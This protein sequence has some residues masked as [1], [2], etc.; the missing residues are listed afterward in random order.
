MSILKL[1]LE[2]RHKPHWG[3]GHYHWDAILKCGAMATM[4]KLE[5]PEEE[6]K[7]L[8][9]G[10]LF[11][12]FMELYFTHKQGFE[13]ADV[14]VSG[15]SNEAWR[16][17][18][19]SYARFFMEDFEP[20]CFGRVMGVERWLPHTEPGE[21]L[22]KQASKITEFFGVDYCAVLDLVVKLTA[23]DVKRLEV[24]HARSGLRLPGPGYYAV[25]HKTEGRDGFLDRLL[26]ERQFV[27]QHALWNICNPKTPLQ[28]V[29]VNVIVKVTKP[30]QRTLFVPPP[31]D[32][33]IEGLLGSLARAARLGRDEPTWINDRNCFTYNRPCVHFAEGRC[34]RSP[35][36]AM[37]LEQK[38]I[39]LKGI[40]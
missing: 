37:R 10:S 28:G 4:N 16:L 20:N 29:L 18:A 6:Q 15:Y 30:W 25:D 39:Q 1:D 24:V 19:E 13:P 33:A 35:R 34:D 2:S 22:P 38:L 8:E 3:H 17:E 12:G 14:E 21:F 9:L 26:N 7:Q 31:D 23:N 40:K 5:P 27:G 32:V 36:T 11:H